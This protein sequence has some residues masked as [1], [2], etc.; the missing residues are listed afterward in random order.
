M[1]PP[2]VDRG[3]GFL[4][5]NAARLPENFDFWDCILFYGTTPR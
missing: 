3:G 2:L 5:K 4:S 1:H